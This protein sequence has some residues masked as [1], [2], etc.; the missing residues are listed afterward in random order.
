MA[1]VDILEYPHP[2]LRQKS[3]IVTQFDD[4]LTSLIVDMFDTM[5]SMKGI[6]LAAPQVGVLQQIII[7]SFE[8]QSFELINPKILEFSGKRDIQ[9]EGCLSMPEVHVDV[10]RHNTIKVR[11]QKRD[12]KSIEFESDG[13]I[14]RIIQ[15]EVDHLD[16]ILITDKGLPK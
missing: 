5:D 3:E 6:G 13:M 9:E 15:H 8:S 7:I 2:V 1:I 11:A 16:G 14:A 10:V 12:G 4:G